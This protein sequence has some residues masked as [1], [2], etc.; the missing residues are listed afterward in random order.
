MQG[1]QLVESHKSAGSSVVDTF[2]EP[3]TMRVTLPKTKLIWRSSCI[4]SCQSSAFFRFLRSERG[5]IASLAS[6]SLHDWCPFRARFSSL[7]ALPAAEEYYWRSSSN[8]QFYISPMKLGALRYL[9]DGSM[10]AFRWLAK[11]PVRHYCPSPH[12]G[13]PGT[14]TTTTS[15]LTVNLW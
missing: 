6:C 12:W 3:A 2:S 7:R 15:L 9:C 1:C 10:E 8:L 5:V 4:R 13:V 14:V 11:L